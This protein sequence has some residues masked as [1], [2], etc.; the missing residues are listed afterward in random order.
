MALSVKTTGDNTVATDGLKSGES[1]RLIDGKQLSERAK[2]EGEWFML[3]NGGSYVYSGESSIPMGSPSIPMIKAFYINTMEVSF[4][5]EVT[6]SIVGGQLI[7]SQT[8]GVVA[9]SPVSSGDLTAKYTNAFL[10]FLLKKD[11][12]VLAVNIKN[13]TSFSH[14]LQIVKASFAST[15]LVTSK[16]NAIPGT[17][18]KFS[19]TI[20]VTN[21]SGGATS[22]TITVLET[23]PSGLRF[24]TASGAGWAASETNGVITIT[25]P[26]VIANA[27]TKVVTINVA[28][29]T[30]IRGSYKTTGWLVDNDINYDAPAIW[31]VGQSITAG[32]GTSN[33]RFTFSYL[34]RNYV[35]DVKGVISRVVNKGLSASTT[36]HHEDSRKFDNRYDPVEKPLAVVYEFGYNDV[37]QSIPSA[38]TLV[39]LVSMVSHFRRYGA[40]IPILV[41]S[42]IP[43]LDAPTEAALITLRSSMQNAVNTLRISDPNVYFIPAT[44]TLWNASTESM[45]NTSDGIHPTAVGNS[46][47]ANAINEF[48]NTNNIF[49]P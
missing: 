24:L 15:E 32:V 11:R 42:P 7:N 43:T 2:S 36:V 39:N 17:N 35:R 47:I 5:E 41:M 49:I 40:N 26:D 33:Y 22:G 44:G 6:F 18:G 31:W 14:D 25:T 13:I 12:A 46:K 1:V 19:Y 28:T 23:L 37:V 34:V 20:T 21:N 45:A 27:G 4:N 9:S 3:G 16:S 30:K 38:T 48:I 10:D 29:K 8:G